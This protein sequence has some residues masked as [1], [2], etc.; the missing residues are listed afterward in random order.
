MQVEEQGAV[1]ASERSICTVA[2]KTVPMFCC[3]GKTDLA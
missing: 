2:Q 3:F 1:L